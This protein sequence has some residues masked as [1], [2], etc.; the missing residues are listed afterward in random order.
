MVY[1][2]RMRQ[3][4]DCE[5][6]LILPSVM[7]KIH[8]DHTFTG[9]MTGRIWLVIR[10]E[11]RPDPYEEMMLFFSFK[12]ALDKIDIRHEPFSSS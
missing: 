12:I 2:V 8:Q 7:I 6:S 9:A 1:F 10:S 11:P 5:T 4:K 3:R